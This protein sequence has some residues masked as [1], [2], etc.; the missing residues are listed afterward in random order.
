MLLTWHNFHS[1]QSRRV[2]KRLHLT[3]VTSRSFSVFVRQLEALR[4]LILQHQLE[5]C[6]CDGQNNKTS[7]RPFS[8]PRL[9]SELFEVLQPCLLVGG[10]LS[11]NSG[12]YL[13]LFSVSA[14]V[15]LT[16]LLLPLSST[17]RSLTVTRG[18]LIGRKA[19][20]SLA[21]PPWMNDSHVCAVN[22]YSM[23]SYST[24]KEIVFFVVVLLSTS[25]SSSFLNDL[26]IFYIFW[27]GMKIIYNDTSRNYFI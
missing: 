19:S 17:L 15:N 16:V 4:Y 21:A 8:L 24:K 23:G 7:H 10:V 2:S 14:A 25:S 5:F 1:A 9:P 13:L 22:Q 3:I 11:Q 6:K 12:E 20:A 26:I 27:G 18:S